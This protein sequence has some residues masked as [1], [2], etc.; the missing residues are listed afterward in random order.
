[1]A[2]LPGM[3]AVAIQNEAMQC[4]KAQ[5]IAKAGGGTVTCPKA[6]DI[7]PIR[8]LRGA[9]TRLTPQETTCI[10]AIHD[11]EPYADD[12]ASACH[13]P[14]DKAEDVAVLI[15]ALELVDRWH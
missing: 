15:N 1:M 12:A 4:R 11:A 8:D 5:L 13:I 2:L 3:V 7:F 9:L 6:D 14:S 10:D